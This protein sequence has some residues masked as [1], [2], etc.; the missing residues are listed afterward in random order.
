[1]LLR[2]PGSML[3]FCLSLGLPVA[4]PASLSPTTLYPTLYPRPVARAELAPGVACSRADANRVEGVQMADEL[5]APR[6]VS[7]HHRTAPH[8][9]EL[10]LYAP[11][12]SWL[13]PHD[14]DLGRW[15]VHSPHGQGQQPLTHKRAKS[16]FVVFRG[17]E[18]H[19]TA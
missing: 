16:F 12:R 11:L 4:P 19:L 7:H 3:L 1:M 8:Y 17:T 15:C 18:T 14:I 10:P 5:N 6:Y 9:T 13:L 2:C